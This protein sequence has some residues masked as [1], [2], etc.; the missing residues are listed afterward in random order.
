MSCGLAR[1]FDLNHSLVRLT[2][3]QWLK[4]SCELK[5]QNY[6]SDFKNL[7]TVIV[8]WSHLRT[9]DISYVT[10]VPSIHLSIHTLFIHLL[11]MTVIIDYIYCICWIRI[12]VQLL[13]IYTEI[14]VVRSGCLL[15]TSLSSLCIHAVLDLLYSSGGIKNWIKEFLISR[16]VTVW[17]SIQFVAPRRIITTLTAISNSHRKHSP[18]ESLKCT[19]ALCYTCLWIISISR[20]L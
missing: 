20:L 6:E 2:I 15:R 12:L 1:T 16:L 10:K 8:F 14:T 17:F 5:T 7:C 19:N 18:S 11:R 9:F 3:Q 4:L 13:H